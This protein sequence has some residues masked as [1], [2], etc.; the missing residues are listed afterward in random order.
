MGSSR[1]HAILFW[2]Y[3]LCIMIM[4]SS[5]GNFKFRFRKIIL[6][7]ILPGKPLFYRNPYQI[8]V[9]TNFQAL[10]NNPW[11][12][13]STMRNKFQLNCVSELKD[14]CSVFWIS[15]R[16][17]LS[18]GGGRRRF[19]KISTSRFECFKNEVQSPSEHKMPAS[20]V[21]ISAKSRSDII[22]RWKGAFEYSMESLDFHSF[23]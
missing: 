14:R 8:K 1:S 3:T 13:C 21:T 4:I 22:G 5:D 6:K 10:D 2:I 7:S 18:V 12:H 19:E 9:S 17:I 23:V 16:E 20:N 11:P 15:C